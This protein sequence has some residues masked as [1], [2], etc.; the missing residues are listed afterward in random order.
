MKKSSKNTDGYES[1]LASARADI[2][3]QTVSRGVSP[4]F[5]GALASGRSIQQILAEHPRLEIVYLPPATPDLNHQEHVWKAARTYVSHNHRFAKLD[6]L[7]HA[8]E[9]HLTSTTFPCSLL[10]HHNYFRSCSMFI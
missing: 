9:P 4:H 7:A 6:Q 2:D 10:A 3:H 8:F 1:G 5:Y